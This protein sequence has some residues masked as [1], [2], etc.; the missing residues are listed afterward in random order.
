MKLLTFALLGAAFMAPFSAAAAGSEQS[1][2]ADGIRAVEAHWSRAFVTGDAAYLR[3]LLTPDYVSVGL[4]GVARDR[5]TIVAASQK[6][7][8]LHKPSASSA[9]SPGMTVRV[10]GTTGIATFESNAQRSVDVFYFAEG[11]WHA[12]YSEHTAVEPSGAAP[13]VAQASACDGAAYH[14]YDFFVGDWDVYKAD[15]TRFAS[16]T[17]TKE[18]DGCAILERWSHNNDKGVGYSA[19]DAQQ[20]RWVQDFFMNDGTVLTFVGHVVGD[21]ILF[22]GIDMPKPGVSERNRVLFRRRS[23]GFEEFWTTSVDGGRTWK[24]V[25]DA[26]F[27]RKA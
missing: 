6:Y 14:A 9:T 24:T 15:G 26:F 8:S 11:S 27:R 17:V 22:E 12:W 1:P 3:T 16:D 2:T 13:G 5:D 7:A 18:M 23:D 19:Y 21:G 10:Q 20:D 4:N 25:F